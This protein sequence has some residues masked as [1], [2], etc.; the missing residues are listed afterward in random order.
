MNQPVI[1]IPRD[2]QVSAGKGGNAW[3]I[4]SGA[5][6]KG[7]EADGSLETREKVVGLLKR[8]G[9][10]YGVI[11]DGTRYGKLEAEF[12]TADGMVSVG[13]SI[14]DSKGGD[15]CSTA[16]LT[17]AE[18]LLLCAKDELIMVTAN[19]AKKENRYGTFATY[20][21]LYKV[22]RVTLATTQLRPERSEGDM[23]DRLEDVIEQL[24]EHPAWGERPERE[25]AAKSAAEVFDVKAKA[26]GWP[27]STHAPVAYC[28]LAGKIAGKTF[29]TLSLIDDDT[30]GAMTVGLDKA[31]SVPKAVA[32][33][34]KA[35]DGA[36]NEA[37]DFDIFAD[38]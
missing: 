28:A 20:A 13:V 34:A 35:F 10:H 3:R 7:R 12:Q 29:K 9:T 36:K 16:A 18:G 24:Q 25:E 37:Q 15:A 11:D 23:M 27:V 1:D 14:T 32:D 38:D 31:K 2:D 22:D 6:C 4:A 30:W 5:I 33:E 17:Y 8:I 21:N 19:R 26:K